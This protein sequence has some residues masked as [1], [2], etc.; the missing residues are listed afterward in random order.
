MAL[1]KRGKWWWTDFSVNG[2]RYRQPIRDKDGQRT[3]DWRE[4]LSREKELIAEAQAGKLSSSSQQFARLSF[5]EAVER[6][7]SDRLPRIQPKTARAEKERARQLKKHFGPTSVG[8]I[9][10]DSVLAYMAERK[11][12]GMSNGTINRDL[13]VLRGVLK[14]AKRWYQMADD[15][16]PLPVRQNVG[17]ALEYDDELRL[18]KLAASKPEW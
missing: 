12:A 11:K 16:R 9:T 7:L 4:A 2:V 17:R 8:R 18:L 10:T 1:F 3:K 14:R 5:S 13:D 6:Y 15:I